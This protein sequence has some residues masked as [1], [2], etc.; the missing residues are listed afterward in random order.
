MSFKVKSA[1]LGL[2][3][4]RNGFFDAL[5]RYV[6]TFKTVMGSYVAPTGTVTVKLVAVA[7]VTVA[8]VAPNFTLLFAAV[9]LKLV[10]VMVIVVPGAPLVGE[11]EVIVGI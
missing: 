1:L 11:K 4:G 8:F 10:P 6:E 9:V 5:V 2:N 7:V 3:V